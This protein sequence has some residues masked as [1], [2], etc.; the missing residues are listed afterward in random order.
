MCL[1][2]VPYLSHTCLILV[3][4]SSHTR[5]ILVSYLSHTCL[6]LVSY[7]SH[8]RLILVSYL[9]HTCPFPPTHPV[10]PTRHTATRHTP[11]HTPTR[12]TLPHVTLPHVTLPHATLPHVSLPHVALGICPPRSPFFFTFPLYTTPD[13]SSGSLGLTRV[14]RR[15][16]R[17]AELS[18]RAGGWAVRA[19]VRFR[20]RVG[21]GFG[22]DRRGSEER[23]AKARTRRAHQIRLVAPRRSGAHTLSPLAHPRGARTRAQAPL[24]GAQALGG[25]QP[26]AHS[27]AQPARD[28]PRALRRRVS[29]ARLRNHAGAHGWK[30]ST[31]LDREPARRWGALARIALVNLFSIIKRYS[32][33]AYTPP[34]PHMSPPRFPHMSEINSSFAVF[35]FREHRHSLLA[36]PEGSALLADTTPDLPNVNS[37]LRYGKP[38][39]ESGRPH[40]GEM[41]VFLFFF[42]C[43]DFWAAAH[44]KAPNSNGSTWSISPTCSTAG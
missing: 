14:E 30:A 3:S 20:V 5:L 44:F 28:A 24:G 19:R 13:S 40:M 26:S 7:L 36:T 16:A 15:R 22:C 37:M 41:G 27:T 23:A 12:H 17:S 33:V 1:I 6:I 2:L 8:T 21:R 34:F 35:V 18:G 4:Y 38:Q 43:S 10:F 42:R 29:V 39:S 32:I 11:T 9:S 31:C 25:A